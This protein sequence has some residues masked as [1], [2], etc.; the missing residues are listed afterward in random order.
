MMGTSL[1]LELSV[2]G[3]TELDAMPPV[4]PLGIIVATGRDISPDHEHPEQAMN[5]LR[6]SA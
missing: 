4:G 3:R 6:R 5:T 2:A 1:I